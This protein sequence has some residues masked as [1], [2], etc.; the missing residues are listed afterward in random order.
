MVHVNFAYAGKQFIRYMLS[1]EQEADAIILYSGWPG[2]ID[3]KQTMEFLVSEG[4]H[5]FNPVY[6]GLYQSHGAFLEDNIIE[7]QEAFFEVLKSG[8]IDNL[9]TQKQETFRI[10][11]T[12][13]FGSSFG[14]SIALGVAAKQEID[15]LVLFAPVWDWSKQEGLDEELAFAKR[16]FK[17]V[18]KIQTTNLQEALL[19][20]PEIQPT[21]YEEKI[22]SDILVLH[23]PQ[24]EIVP[25]EQ[26]EE[27]T[28]PKQVITHPYGHS[29]S[30]PLEAYWQEILSF[31][32]THLRSA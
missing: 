27:I 5:V 26:T 17:N 2:E 15:K 21:Y 8:I 32:S 1:E 3:N 18:Y 10:N 22:T 12:I 9:Y 7:E 30:E 16:A 31:L 24:D 14:G 29:M 25:Y 28:L 13:V 4:F 6:P 19:K 23:D 20:L 11:K